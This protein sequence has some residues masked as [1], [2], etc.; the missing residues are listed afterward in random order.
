MVVGFGQG[1]IDKAHILLEK[2]TILLKLIKLGK[3][4]FLALPRS[5]LL[6]SPALHII[7]VIVGS[8]RCFAIAPSL[9]YF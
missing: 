7:F 6:P 4:A 9:R 5:S 1:C 2:I 8:L 3:Q